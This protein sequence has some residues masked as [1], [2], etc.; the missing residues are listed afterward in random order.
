MSMTKRNITM[1]LIVG[2]VLTEIIPDTGMVYGMEVEVQY[3]HTTTVLEEYN[4]TTQE[5][6]DETITDEETTS[7][8]TDMTETDI[9]EEVSTTDITTK[10]HITTNRPTQKP[11]ETSGGGTTRPG[12]SNVAPTY[13]F[14]SSDTS[15]TPVKKSKKKKISYYIVSYTKKYEM[16]KKGIAHT[17]FFV[18]CKRNKVTNVNIIITIQKKKNGKWYDYNKIKKKKTGFINY[19]DAQ[20][21][22]KDKGR[23]RMKAAAYLYNGQKYLGSKIVK[24]YGQNRK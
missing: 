11:S 8:D 20:T 12:D 22:I 5:I 18:E 10:E 6:Q 4:S 1:I 2:L 21:Y 14:A 9:P 16:K 3:E 19:L 15:V 24:T 17:K 13:V 7:C 23:Y